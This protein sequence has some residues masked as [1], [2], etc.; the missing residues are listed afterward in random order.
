MNSYCTEISKE[1]LDADGL[2][3]RFWPLRLTMPGEGEEVTEEK[4][5]IPHWVTDEEE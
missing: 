1:F 5:K 4:E 3:G 2:G